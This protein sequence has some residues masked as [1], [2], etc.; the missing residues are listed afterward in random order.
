MIFYGIK[1]KAKGM[2]KKRKKLPR[3]FL[4]TFLFFH[5]RPLRE[6]DGCGVSAWC[7]QSAVYHLL[8]FWQ[9]INKKAERNLYERRKIACACVRRKILFHTSFFFLL[10]ASLLRWCISMFVDALHKLLGVFLWEL[11][12]RVVWGEKFEISH[13][14]SM[15]PHTKTSFG[16]TRLSF[17][18][19]L[20]CFSSHTFDRLSMRRSSTGSL[21]TSASSF[22]FQDSWTLS[23]WTPFN[24]S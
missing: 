5:R 7:N 16:K 23:K 13:F 3:N 8:S 22:R 2:R 15:P 14:N 21:L 17:L 9:N 24:H 11:N 6:R 4:L 20:S 18:S 10:L 19:K 12:A 1:Q